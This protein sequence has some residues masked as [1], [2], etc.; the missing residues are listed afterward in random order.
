MDTSEVVDLTFHVRGLR[1]ERVPGAE[2]RFLIEGLL[3][4]H[5][6]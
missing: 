1:T 2:P 6:F 4:L 3:T 5:T